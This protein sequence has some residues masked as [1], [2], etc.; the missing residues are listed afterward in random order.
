MMPTAVVAAPALLE[1]WAAEGCPVS[2]TICRSGPP[3]EVVAYRAF[4]RAASSWIAFSHSHEQETMQ[5][6][7]RKEARRWHELFPGAPL[8]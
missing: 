4:D 6:Q 8:L 3:Q 5:R 7:L 2:E 1:A